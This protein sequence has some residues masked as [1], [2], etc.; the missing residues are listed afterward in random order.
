[1]YRRPPMV[2]VGQTTGTA[3]L[4]ATAETRS[5]PL[6]RSKATSSPVSAST[7]VISTRGAAG[8]S[9]LGSRP[10]MT[11]RRVCSARCPRPGGVP[12]PAQRLPVVAGAQAGGA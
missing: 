10:A 4:A 2:T 5:T 8:H 12:Q 11:S 1:M 7:A 9:W 3:Q 6:S